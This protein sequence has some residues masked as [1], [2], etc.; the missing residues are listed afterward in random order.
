MGQ[1]R[2]LVSLGLALGII[3]KAAAGAYADRHIFFAYVLLVL[4]AA[5]VIAA[6][7]HHFVRRDRVVARVVTNDVE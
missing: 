3:G 4:I 7:W 5:H 2:P 6:L 1:R